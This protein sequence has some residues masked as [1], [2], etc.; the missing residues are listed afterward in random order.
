MDIAF[1]TGIHMPIFDR[2]YNKI[3]FVRFIVTIRM[4]GI[5]EIEIE[6]YVLQIASRPLVSG[7][8]HNLGYDAFLSSEHIY[9]FFS[10]IVG[11]PQFS[12]NLVE[13]IT[14]NL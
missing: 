6:T 2:I 7:F 3:P 11:S 5:T 8:I 4:T 12:D 13:E 1:T 10:L 9:A 14:G